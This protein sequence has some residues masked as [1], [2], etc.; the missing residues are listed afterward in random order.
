MRKASLKVKL[1]VV[2]TLLV[3]LIIS[4]A[5]GILFSL[6]SREIL[7]STQKSLENRVQ[8]SVDDIES[9]D[10]EIEID[11][12]FY[13]VENGIYLSVRNEDG[14]LLYGKVPYGFNRQPEFQSGRV[15]TIREG[16]KNWYVY[17]L[18]Y[19]PEKGVTV[20]IRGVTS[21][22]DAEESF[23]VTLRFSLILFPLLAAAMAVIGYRI[24]RR[25]LLPVKKITHTVQQIRADKDLSRRVELNP[26]QKMSRDEIYDLADTFDEMLEQLEEVFQREQRFT[27]DVS[28]EL[29]T[30]L[31]VILA[32]CDACL[33][34]DEMT[35]TQ[36]APIRLIQRKAEEMSNMVSQLLLLS[37]ADEGRQQLDRERL[38]ISEITQMVVEEQQMLAEEQEK[39]VEISMDIEPDLY[40]LADESFYIRML[41]NLISN[42]VFYSKDKG[43]VK[44]SL[45]QKDKEIIGV[46]EDNG[47]GI[48]EKDLPHIWER[49]YRA[50]PSRTDGS[51]SGLGLPMVEWIAKAH[52]GWV[53]AE[54]KQGVGTKFIF[55]IPL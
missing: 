11:T 26:A 3:V 8:E 19:R 16:G 40:A 25:T 48:S 9:E 37:R 45:F 34:G 29:R 13:S 47:I 2:Y 22:T 4:A 32:Q 14:Y 21:I 17:D 38:N 51:H 46:V 7:A 33:S 24:T 28:H 5:L 6:S 35:D 44:V 18:S 39:E 15:R 27:S 50:D 52:G 31:S 30:P 10:G 12:D 42:G 55:C 23:Q 43:N 41:V 1:T 53:T 49:F 54:S 20:Y 36:K